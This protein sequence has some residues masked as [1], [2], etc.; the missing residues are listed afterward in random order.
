MDGWTA[1]PLYLVDVPHTKKIYSTKYNTRKCI[2]YNPPY[3]VSHI[4]VY[5]YI[6]L[7]S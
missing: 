3:M 7:N 5:F 1:F 4:S 2:K 6:Q